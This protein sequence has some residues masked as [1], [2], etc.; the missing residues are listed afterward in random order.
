MVEDSERILSV[1][2]F[3]FSVEVECFEFL[4]MALRT[5]ES[6]AMTSVA[7]TCFETSETASNLCLSIKK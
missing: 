2:V 6:S 1:V 5:E 4:S 7:V 3:E